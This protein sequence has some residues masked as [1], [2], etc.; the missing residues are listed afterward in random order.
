MV[1]SSK[2]F[3]NIEDSSFNVD[4]LVFARYDS[5]MSVEMLPEKE[6]VLQILENVVLGNAVPGNVAEDDVEDALGVDAYISKL[7]LTNLEK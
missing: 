1:F 2:P 5:N 7:H 3:F 4:I 6:G